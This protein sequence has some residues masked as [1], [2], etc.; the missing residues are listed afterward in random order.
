VPTK[1]PEDH[2]ARLAVG[3]GRQGI[4]FVEYALGALWQ[5]TAGIARAEGLS[6]S[7]AEAIARSTAVGAVKAHSAALRAVVKVRRLG[8]AG[9]GGARL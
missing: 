6:A 1:R 2:L 4:R 5:T 9:R 8:G 3:A 7:E